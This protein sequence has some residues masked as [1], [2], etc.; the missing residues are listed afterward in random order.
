[1]NAKVKVVAAIA[2]LQLI[3]PTVFAQR[4]IIAMNSVYQVTGR[5][6]EVDPSRIVIRSR[7]TNP[8]DWVL[9]RREDTRFWAQVQPGDLV[10]VKYN[11]MA[12]D[13]TPMAPVRTVPPR[14]R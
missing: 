2:A 7:G 4:A 5:V 12:T 6:V 14:Y 1:M 13:V 8:G 11:M 3:V 9:L 10:T